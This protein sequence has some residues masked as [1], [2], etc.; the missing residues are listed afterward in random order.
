MKQP[1]TLDIG[2]QMDVAKHRLRVAK[3]DLDTAKLTFDAGQ[4]RAANTN[5]RADFT[6][7]GKIFGRRCKMIM[8]TNVERVN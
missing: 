7:G 8:R 6:F 5:C 3:E 1:N 2:T 4:F